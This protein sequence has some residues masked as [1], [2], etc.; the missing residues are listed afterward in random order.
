MAE[1]PDYKL[2]VCILHYGSPSLTA[3]VYGQLRAEPDVFVLDNAAPEP[4]P[5]A[6]LRLPENLYWAGA[7]DWAVT[8][9][10]AAGYTHLWF[11]NNDAYFLSRR[12]ILRT[13]IG[14]LARMEQVLGRVGVYAPAVS[15]SPYHP[16]MLANPAVQ[17]R[18][19]AF[20]DGIAPLLNLQCVQEIGGV[21]A[22]DN[23]RGYG[24][25]IWLSLRAN[26]A[27]WLV[28]VDNQVLIR[29]NYHSTAGE[30][31]GF[32]ERAAL[33][34]ARFLGRRLGP[35]YQHQIQELQSEC[36]EISNL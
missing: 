13:V 14:R 12:P 34:E 5:G 36:R 1:K 33:A 23:P 15:V 9:F 25:D 35:D 27:G 8:R 10:A 7:L 2:A 21:D 17:C 31:P 3:R 20:V 18:A 29:H 6:W 26:R 11:L 16:Q 30:I 19:A 32:L 22:A 24:V 28:L 4:F